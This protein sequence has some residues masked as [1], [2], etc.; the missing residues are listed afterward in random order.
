VNE[1]G[2]ERIPLL[3]VMQGGEYASQPRA[4]VF[5]PLRGWINAAILV[6]THF[7]GV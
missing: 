5:S 4:T 6:F 7:H 3:A 2:I 1:C